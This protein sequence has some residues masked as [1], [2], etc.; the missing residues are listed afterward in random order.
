M[1]KLEQEFVWE[2][3]YGDRSPLVP[4]IKRI[5]DEQDAD[6]L[7]LAAMFVNNNPYGHELFIVFSYKDPDAGQIEAMREAMSGVGA[8]RRTDLTY[9]ELFDEMSKG[10]FNVTTFLNSGLVDMQF[11]HIFF[12]REKKDIAGKISMRPLGKKPP[13][14]LSHASGDKP[15]IEELSPYLNAAGMSV[16][17]DKS[18]IDYGQSIVDAVQSGVETSGAVIFWVTKS[19]LNS[20]WCKTEMRN[21]LN[22]YSGGHNV[23]IITVVSDEVRHEDLPFFLRDLKYLRRG[24]G[25]TVAAVAKEIIPSLKK[26]F[27]LR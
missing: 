21:F 25:M 6:Q 7:G 1:E 16:W 23:L 27:N 8:R 9:D 12:H 18:N 20:D 14:F 4:V 22:R 17:F 10:R 11:K 15:E 5:L 19:F 2:C 24:K 13:V 3:D 26:H